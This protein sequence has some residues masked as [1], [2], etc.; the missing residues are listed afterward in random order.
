[1]INSPEEQVILIIFSYLIGAMSSSIII[2]RI[3]KVDITKIGSGNAGATNTVRAL[4]KKYGAIVLVLDILKGSLPTMV[5]KSVS[6]ESFILPVACAF[7]TVLGH[8]FPIYFSFKGGKGAATFIGTIIVIFPL[9]ALICFLVWISILILSGYVGLATITAA[10]IFPISVFFFA[11]NSLI[12]FGISST[13]FVLIAH[14][15]NIIRLFQGKE[16]R[17]DN[18]YIFNSKSFWHK[19]SNK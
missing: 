7:A 12:F 14:Y 1:M 17:F 4:G 5:A 9:G 6:P 10:I 19:K 2:C 13:I 15:K 3:K 16:S 8:V 18:I 11:E